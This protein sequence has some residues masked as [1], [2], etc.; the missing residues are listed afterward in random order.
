M[1]DHHAL[2][3]QPVMREYLKHQCCQKKEFGVVVSWKVEFVVE[4]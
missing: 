4:V 2:Q 1:G 3:I